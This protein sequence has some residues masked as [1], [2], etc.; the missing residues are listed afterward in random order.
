MPARRGAT[1][2]TSDSE[3]SGGQFLRSGPDG[4]CGHDA[5]PG[6]RVQWRAPAD[7]PLRPQ[8]GHSVHTPRAGRAADV[9]WSKGHRKLPSRGSHGLTVEPGRPSTASVLRLDRQP[10]AGPKGAGH[11]TPFTSPVWVLGRGPRRPLHPAQPVREG[12]E[13][14]LCRDGGPLYPETKRGGG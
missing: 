9:G 7:G 1:P 2:S 5:L 10:R 11:V 3:T 4:H 12:S 14:G 13:A 6:R 8:Q